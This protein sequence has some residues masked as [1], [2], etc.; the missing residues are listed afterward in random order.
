MAEISCGEG[1]WVNSYTEQM[2]TVSG[3]NPDDTLCSLSSGW[4]LIGLKSNET[5]SI[6]G[7]IT[8]NEGK[9]ASIWKWI[10]NTWA[11]YL[12][13]GGTDTYAQSKGFSVLDT[14]KPG[15]G[16]WVNCSEPITLE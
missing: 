1:F 2:L 4:N 7:L 8:G 10:N 16:F 6:T 12:P 9:I 11:V 13:G 3:T 14:I 15:E 5:Q